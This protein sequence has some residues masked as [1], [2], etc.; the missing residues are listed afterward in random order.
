MFGP[1]LWTRSGSSRRALAAGAVL[2]LLLNAP[3]S[4]WAQSAGA[5]EAG[6]SQ[7]AQ[8]KTTTTT[9]DLPKNLLTRPLTL[10]G[11]GFFSF[12]NTDIQLN[13]KNTNTDGT[14]VNLEN[15][16]GLDTFK[17]TPFGEARWRIT[18]HHRVELGVF[19]LDRDGA[20][21]ADTQLVIDDLVIEVGASAETE[22]DL[23]LGRF[24]YGYSFINDGKKEL[25]VMVGAHIA[26]LDYDV[27]LTGTL[28]GGSAGVTST[29]ENFTAPLPHVGVMGGYAF[30]DDLV[31]DARLVGFYLE[32][33]DYS[34]WLLEAETKLTY[35][36]WDNVGLGVGARYFKFHLDADSS[37]LD[38]DLDLQFLGPTAFRRGDLLRPPGSRFMAKC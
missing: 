32:I 38:G 7:I 28:G 14:N 26:S 34:G 20:A 22:L 4:A 3:A 6:A 36:I 29:G 27:S 37:S 15:D 13:N 31:L 10:I 19:A 25:G 18:P 12:S 9:S 33:S 17:A 21:T 11:G 8:T 5:A 1:E 30:R 16:L 35:M 24:T 23:T 2:A